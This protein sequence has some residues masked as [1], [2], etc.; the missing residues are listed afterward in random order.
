MKLAKSE[1]KTWA[2]ENLKGIQN[3]LIPSFDPDTLQLDEEGIRWDVRQTIEHGFV[4][5]LCVAEAGLSM[6]ESKKFLKIVADEAKDDLIVSFTAMGD[7]I[8]HTLEMLEH[9]EKVGCDCAFIDYPFSF[10]PKSEDEIYDVTKKMCDTA[11]L[12][13]FLHALPKDNFMALHPSGYAPSLL[14]RLS[15]IEN[16]VA[17]EITDAGLIAEYFRV[18]GDKIVLQ[19]PL[20]RFMPL[21]VQQFGLQLMGPGTYELYQSPEKRYLVDYFD[22]L[23]KGDYDKAM[24]IYWSL[25]PVRI[26]FE[27]KIMQMIPNG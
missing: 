4:A 1:M 24:E 5:T 26:P 10:F 12:A 23:L 25:T 2:K 7:T 15:D 6:D 20:E 18:C 21:M 9:A 16:V 3:C 14:S 19:C 17:A 13:I 27:M 8:N 22:L 11:N